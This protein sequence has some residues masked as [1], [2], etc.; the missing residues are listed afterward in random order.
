LKVKWGDLFIYLAFEKEDF[1]VVGGQQ[2][3][4]PILNA[5]KAAIS[6]QERHYIREDKTW[7][8][9]NNEHNKAVVTELSEK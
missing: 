2:K 1:K 4:E 5:L 9:D 3:Y 8:I 7:V 6:E